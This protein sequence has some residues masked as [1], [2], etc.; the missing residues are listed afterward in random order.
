M[1][2][3]PT[4]STARPTRREQLHAL[5]VAF[6]CAIVYLGPSLLPGRSLVPYPPE[7]HEPRMSEALEAGMSVAEIGRGNLSMG[8]KYN[9]SLM[10]DRV[11]EQRFRA[12]EFPLWTRDIGGGAP[13]VPQMGQPY[14]PW[15][16]LL[17][18]WSSTEWY[19]PVVLLQLVLIGWF[20]YR[21]F[22]RVDCRH[23]SS[24][25]G[26][27]VVLLGLWMQGRIHQNVVISAA[28]PL[29][30]MLSCIHDMF[31]GKR[32]L[33]AIG[34]FA[35]GAGLT[36]SAG[37][38]P[39]SLQITYLC[40]A[41]GITLAIVRRRVRPLVFVGLGLALGAVV[42]LAQMIPVLLAAA[43]SAREQPTADHLA[44]LGADFANLLSML[45]P[46]LLFWPDP[47]A[48]SGGNSLMSLLWLDALLPQPGVPLP[49]LNY[50]EMVFSTGLVSTIGIAGLIG[51]GAAVRE[52]APFLI[53]FALVVVLGLG[54]ASG[55]SPFLELSAAIPGARAGDL[56]RFLFAVYVGM[57][58]LSTFGV[59][60]IVRSGRSTSPR[61]I[62]AIAA[63]GSL[64]LLWFASGTEEQ[65]TTRFA[66]RLV[67]R[68]G[69]FAELTI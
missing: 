23:V 25:F 7:Y 37:F 41:F 56:R 29:F 18:V 69:A 14:E 31:G 34:V 27:V 26:I 54:L 22:R 19:G 9:Q 36:W 53:L 35:I 6:V 24:L 42:A 38:A 46:D 11:I 1:V 20:A 59:D 60:R 57:A 12:G 58:I 65:L 50:T 32:I 52:R 51:R 62:A 8:D 39:V 5:L 64:V 48:M 40:I 30:F 2:D 49:D 45:W 33:R 43:E 28:L 15:N 44:R 10:W 13:F 3:A 61:V 47:G 16:L 66:E 21:F 63:I 17:F 67:D 68:Y 55:T 4:E